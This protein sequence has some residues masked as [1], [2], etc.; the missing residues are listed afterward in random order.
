MSDGSE[1][2]STGAACTENPPTEKT[3]TLIDAEEDEP[4]TTENE[5]SSEGEA[6][7]SDH[8][9]DD[10]DLSSDGEDLSTGIESDGMEL[11]EENRREFI[12]E[13]DGMNKKISVL[14]C[15]PNGVGKSTLLNGLMGEEKWFHVE[16][17]LK[18]GTSKVE[19]QTDFC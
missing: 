4:C 12:Q 19:E 18:R 13:I 2:D 3:P 11:N 16:D 10:E 9:S 14:C 15:G 1:H 17:S 7:I 5:G 8:H 6:H